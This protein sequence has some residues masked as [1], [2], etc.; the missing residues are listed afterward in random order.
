[1]APIEIFIVDD[2]DVVREGLEAILGREADLV[3]VGSASSGE[4]ALPMIA[5]TN[6]HV[7][8]VDYRLP[9]ADGASLC[10]EIAESR[11]RA[12]VVIL[13]AFIEEASVQAALFAGARAYVVK[14]VDTSEMIR[15]IRHAAAGVTT[16]DPIVTRRYPGLGR[17][18][19]SSEPLTSQSRNVLRGVIDG[20]TAD[21]IAKRAGI[22]PHTVKAHLRTIYER[23]D[24]NSRAEAVAVAL[25]RG[26]M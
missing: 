21:E 16:I 11:L 7:V 26:L 19:R 10:C 5:E 23:L 12:Q 6:P 24:V 4:E 20:L 18:P 22:S 15:A 17:S 8:V 3:V 9:G 2:H 1:M 13:S 25:R 14:D